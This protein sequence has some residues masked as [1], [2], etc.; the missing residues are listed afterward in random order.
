MTHSGCGDAYLKCYAQG[1]GNRIDVNAPL[2]PMQGGAPRPSR[3]GASFEHASRHQ[4]IPDIVF[5]RFSNGF[6][7]WFFCTQAN[8]TSLEWF[9]VCLS[10]GRDLAG[11]T[12]HG[13]LRPFQLTG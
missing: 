5:L 8:Y 6:R 7:T 11:S 1:L 10:L 3:L 12:P 2:A 9:C 4:R 13:S